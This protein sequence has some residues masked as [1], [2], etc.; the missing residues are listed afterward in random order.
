MPT[1][2]TASPTLLDYLVRLRVLAAALEQLGWSSQL[3]GA[4][5]AEPPS[6][7]AQNPVPGAGVLSEHITVDQGKDGQWLYYWSWGEPIGEG[8]SAAAAVI[9][10]VLRPADV[11]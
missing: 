11:S 8:A 9:V 5:G 4:H 6:L 3:S 2:R 10:R 7:Y 1:V